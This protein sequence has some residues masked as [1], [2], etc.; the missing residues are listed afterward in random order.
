M[1]IKKTGPRV[2]IPVLSTLLRIIEARGECIRCWLETVFDLKPPLSP[3][4][5]SDLRRFAKRG[6][7]GV[8]SVMTRFGSDVPN[9]S[10]QGVTVRLR[11]TSKRTLA[12][13]AALLS[14]RTY[15]PFST[16]FHM[17]S[18][19]RLPAFSFERGARAPWRLR[20]VPVLA[21]KVAQSTLRY[22]SR[23]VILQR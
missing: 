5:L 9:L 14:Q 8:T 20:K 6:H 15:G 19:S 1:Q 18:I 7:R 17:P 10:S 13:Q 12:P 11:Y 2:L 4:F 22:N 21:Q 16:T 3:P 23:G